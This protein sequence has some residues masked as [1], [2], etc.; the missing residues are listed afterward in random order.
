MIWDGQTSTKFTF[1]VVYLRPGLSS[2]NSNSW[3]KMIKYKFSLIH[4]NEKT[5]SCNVNKDS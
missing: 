1:S 5:C 2:P 3:H 4:A